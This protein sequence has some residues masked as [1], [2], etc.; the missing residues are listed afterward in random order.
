MSQPFFKRAS[1]AIRFIMPLGYPVPPWA[2]PNLDG[3]EQISTFGRIQGISHWGLLLVPR[4]W[5]G[6]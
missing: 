4:D 5:R 1:C 3:V 2:N 6:E